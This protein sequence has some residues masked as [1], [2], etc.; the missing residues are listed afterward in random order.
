MH[1]APKTLQNEM[2]MHLR[3]IKNR[4]QQL[5]DAERTINQSAAHIYL[6]PK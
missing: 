4:L 5:P 3:E 6:E 2:V 1:T